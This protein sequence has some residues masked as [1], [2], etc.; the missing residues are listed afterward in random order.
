[1]IDFKKINESIERAVVLLEANWVD[2]VNTKYK[3]PKGLFSKSPSAIAGELLSAHK[4]G[5]SAMR[6]LLFFINRAGNKLS[7]EDRARMEKAKKALSRL[8]SLTKPR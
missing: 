7:S 5:R 1:M 8:I 2:T 4:G 3:P 6:S